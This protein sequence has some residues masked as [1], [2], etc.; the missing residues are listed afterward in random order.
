MKYRWG[1][2]GVVILVAIAVY[3]TRGGSE[4]AVRPAEPI[5]HGSGS[6]TAAK[7]VQAGRR[8]AGVVERDGAPV[9]GAPVQLTSAVGDEQRVSDAG[10]RF[11]FG[12]QPARA[13]VVSA[14]L[15]G[16]TGAVLAI[17]LRTDIVAD[18][19]HLVLHACDASV[20]GTV[21]DVAGGVIPNARV[22]HSLNGELADLSTLTGADGNYELCIPAGNSSLQVSADGYATSG[23]WLAAFGKTNHD[24]EL[25]PEAVIHGRVEPAIAGA[26]V[27]L[28][29]STQFAGLVHATTDADGHFQFSGALPGKHA[30]T[31][32]ADGMSTERRVEIVAKVGDNP[33]V[34]LAMSPAF[35]V[36]GKVV[37]D[38]KHVVAGVGLMLAADQGLIR[39]LSGADGTFSFSSVPRGDYRLFADNRR[40]RELAVDGDVRD[41]VLT[42]TA[43]VAVAGLVTRK[44]QPVDGVT[45]MCGS[46]VVTSGVDGRYA[47]TCEKGSQ[48]LYAESHRVGAFS[49]KQVEIS[50]PRNDLDIELDLVGS[51]AG[52]VVDQ[53]GA[54]VGGVLV[55]CRLPS[56]GDF[57]GSNTG[58][59]G[60][61]NARSMSGGGTYDCTVSKNDRSQPFKLVDEKAGQVPLADGTSAV[62][63][64]RLAIRVDHLRIAGKVIDANGAP[65]SDVQ[66]SVQSETGRLETYSDTAG[67]FGFREVAQG[68]YMVFAN[69]G[70]VMERNVAAGRTDLVLQLPATGSLEGTL[71]GFSSAPRIVLFNRSGGDSASVVMTPTGFHADNLAVG[72]YSVDAIARDASARGYV[73]VVAGQVAHVAL[74][75]L[76]TG[77]IEGTIRDAVTHEPR[78]YSYCAATVGTNAV[79]GTTDEDGAYAIRNV[80]AGKVTVTCDRDPSE[81]VVEVVAGKTTRLDV[82]ITLPFVLGLVLEDRGN[83][84]FVKSVEPGSVAANAGIAVDD[85]VVKLMGRPMRVPSTYMAKMMDGMLEYRDVPLELERAGK[86]IAITLTVPAK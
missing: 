10:G 20:F 59:D 60:A 80:V 37:D 84:V 14:Q 12:P 30:L 58:A 16:V 79:T 63:G 61:F 15:P 11:D 4:D 70:A 57:G 35:V 45:V 34:V 77:R 39:A 7:L 6:P 13:Y 83:N 3:L 47:T 29:T 52:T 74:T 2:V 69:N 86:P 5:A 65:A 28:S 55:E 62:T 64:V 32:I 8:I 26:D 19:L 54:P 27:E 46:S 51:I 41:L 21:R 31:A 25:L 67:A 40:M 73:D 56:T 81:H 66:V 68:T 82:D 1:A 53:D 48:R 18:A 43:R 85:R 9:A 78:A 23:H 71:T 17:D 42:V 22:A 75:A 72:M 36:A 24:V 49:T 44:H 76:A 50:G 38:G 33:E